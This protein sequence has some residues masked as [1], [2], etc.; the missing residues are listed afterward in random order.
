M[1]L[2]CLLL[3]GERQVRKCQLIGLSSQ[4]SEAVCRTLRSAASFRV[5]SADF[6]KVS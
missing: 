4:L 3:G 6:K 1:R 2:P 5:A